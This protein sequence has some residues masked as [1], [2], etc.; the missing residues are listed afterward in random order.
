ME[1][2]NIDI[3]AF[4]LEHEEDEFSVDKLPEGYV[5]TKRASI[6][7]GYEM[8]KAEGDIVP[9][10]QFEESIDENSNFGCTTYNYEYKSDP[11]FPYYAKQLVDS[12]R[13]T[14]STKHF[15]TH[16]LSVNVR[17]DI[18]DTFKDR[19]FD[20]A[21]NRDEFLRNYSQNRGYG[22][23]KDGVPYRKSSQSQ[24]MVSLGT[25]YTKAVPG[26]HFY[27]I[28]KKTWEKIYSKIT[29]A[30]IYDDKSVDDL[31]N[32]AGSR[33]DRLNFVVIKYKK[34]GE[35]QGKGFKETKNNKTNNIFVINRD[36]H[37]QLASECGVTIHSQ[38]LTDISQKKDS[39]ICGQVCLAY[40][41]RAYGFDVKK[42]F[43]DIKNP[44]Y[45]PIMNDIIDLHFNDSTSKATKIN[46]KTTSSDID[47][48]N[49]IIK[50]NKMDSWRESGKETA[51]NNAF[52]Y[53]TKI[54]NH[55]GAMDIEDFKKVTDIFPVFTVRIFKIIESQ[56]KLIYECG[57][58]DYP[59][60]INLLLHDSHYYV[61]RD[62]KNF[63]NDEYRSDYFFCNKCIT[64]FTK[65]SFMKNHGCG[66]ACKHCKYEYNSVED[67]ASHHL[68]ILAH[69][70]N[71]C[72]ICN[73]AFPYKGC[74]LKH[75][76]DLWKCWE[77]DGKCSIKHSKKHICGERQC[78][79]CF[80]YYNPKTT[81][82]ICY[83][84]NL[85]MPKE[86]DLEGKTKQDMYAFDFEST[87]TRVMDID[88]VSVTAVGPAKFAANYF[89]K[90]RDNVMREYKLAL[91][92]ASKQIIKYFNG[93]NGLGWDTS[94][95]RTEGGELSEEVINKKFQNLD[96][97]LNLQQ[98]EEYETFIRNVIDIEDLRDEVW[99]IEKQKRF[100][101]LRNKFNDLNETIFQDIKMIC[102]RKLYS[103]ERKKFNSLKEFA[104]WFLV[105]KSPTKFFAHNGGKYDNYILK[106]YLIHERLI[107]PKKIIT[108]GKR[109]ITMDIINCEFNDSMNH[110]NKSL[111]A[112]GE[113]FNIKE[114]KGMF[115]YRFYTDKTLNYIGE[116]PDKKYFE[117]EKLKP[118]KKIEFELWYNTWKELNK[119]GT[120]YDIN[121]E[122]E[123]YCHNDVDILCK[124]LEKYRDSC[125]KLNNLDPLQ[126]ITI[127]Q[128]AMRVYRVSHLPANTIGMLDREMYDFVDKSF[129]GGRTE[130]RQ[131]Y[132]VWTPEDIA[133]GIYGVYVDI[134]SMYPTVQKYDM[135]PY[136]HATWIESDILKRLNN[137]N[138]CHK[139][140]KNLKRDSKVAIVHC[141]VKCPNNLEHAVLLQ[142][143]DHKLLA[144]LDITEGH[145]TSAELIVAI[146]KGYEITSIVN[147]LV[148]K[149]AAGILFN[150][151]IAKYIEIKNKHSANGTEPNTGLREIAKMMLNSLWG[152]FAQKEDSGE[153]KYFNKTK[154]VEWDKLINRYN[155]DEV[156]DIKISEA[157]EDYIYVSI[158]EQITPHLKLRSTNLMLASFVTANARLR[159]F[160]WLDILGDRVIYH[161]TD[162][163]VYEYNKNLVNIPTGHELGEWEEECNRISLWA[164]LAAKTY[165]Y[166]GL[167]PNTDKP[168]DVIKS[169]GFSTGFT[170]DEYCTY[171]K[172]FFNYLEYIKNTPKPKEL[173]QRDIC[174]T[175]EKYVTKLIASMNKPPGFT[176]DKYC[177][178]V[179]EFYNYLED[180]KNNSKPKELVQIGRNYIIIKKYVEKLAAYLHKST[181]FTIDE[182]CT[183]VKE[184]FNYLEDIK[185]NP[186]PKELVQRGT[187]F[188][189]GNCITIEKY[190]KKLAA[191]MHKAAVI[192]CSRTVP[193]GHKDEHLA[194]FKREK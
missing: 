42:Y 184:F 8:L 36:I 28:N 135:L 132:K 149:A 144:S 27:E 29:A 137:S 147:A 46:I 43:T 139:W 174:I 146:E 19:S 188:K 104:D 53:V 176:I 72:L 192:S 166:K 92:K 109:I 89:V 16:K 128:Y 84:N 76:C 14:L 120:M 118:D 177:T 191:S 136:G 101:N 22:N 77:C 32:K 74:L 108:A 133:N 114:I 160:G 183:Y 156:S 15:D 90:K 164:A 85:K 71:R 175:I 66:L 41:F 182:S 52:D 122:C 102:V 148:S 172:E 117:T 161:D 173:V 141:K 96:N 158:T 154:G 129:I 21:V 39:T 115:P 130:C 51:Y 107:I 47:D 7:K 113:T 185:N 190:V 63:M 134:V 68:P 112:C 69:E 60:Y 26:S 169:K 123:K 5:S 3:T 40:C 105:L 187:M 78:K 131:M 37:L 65:V 35:S 94:N 30:D 45:V 152:K 4:G 110:I 98:C 121:Y 54:I 88:P 179:K 163:I 6:M 48:N 70:T 86:P 18:D 2:E 31:W 83:I 143:K 80:K 23:N 138:M 165:A 81:Q 157:T 13:K 17:Y 151:Y 49:V 1:E 106:Q 44:K 58:S 24:D 11:D 82:H 119:S 168:K 159:L 61:I 56:R 57:N 64:T 194:L 99:A 142:K 167:V 59:R 111:S 9:V 193:F 180:I 38:S 116:I 62:L 145:F 67:K 181:G 127:A 75:E 140:L 171:V 50:D 25:L 124:S 103:K 33:M 20:S 162:S 153:T 73:F 91:K 186:K 97:A 55:N 79:Q 95:I 150:S 126:S 10:P 178:Y 34:S 100:T 93:F 189:R 87:S 12:F 170:I 125:I 155:L